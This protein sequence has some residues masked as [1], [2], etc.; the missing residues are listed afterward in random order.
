M[1]VS[2]FFS[3]LNFSDWTEVGLLQQLFLDRH[4]KNYPILQ[5]FY[6]I[7]EMPRLSVMTRS[8][9]II[10]DHGFFDTL[11]QFL[12]K[13]MDGP[14]QGMAHGPSSMILTHDSFMMSHVE[15]FVQ[16]QKFS[17]TVSIFV[18]S[19]FFLSL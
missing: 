7:R 19:V 6:K 18:S 2:G 14:W 17:L 11:L 15:S 8:W 3:M 1:P 16:S 9:K 5:R 4:L 10:H 13:I 12:W